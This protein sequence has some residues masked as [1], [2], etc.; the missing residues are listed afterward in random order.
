MLYLL[1]S[2]YLL[3]ALS[4]I[5]KI[6]KRKLAQTNNAMDSLSL[7]GSSNIVV[8]ATKSIVSDF[9][10]KLVSLDFNNNA[11]NNL[12]SKLNLLVL[13]AESARQFNFSVVSQVQLAAIFYI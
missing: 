8:E 6:R 9:N 4:A 1:L 10:S 5:L 12:N 3:P 11:R 13:Q 2:F 7:S